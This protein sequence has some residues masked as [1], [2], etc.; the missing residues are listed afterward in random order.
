[1]NAYNTNKNVIEEGDMFNNPVNF[2][3]PDGMMSKNGS[4]ITKFPTPPV[5]P[6]NYK[7]GSNMMGGHRSRHG[8]LY[9]M[10]VAMNSRSTRRKRHATSKKLTRR[11]N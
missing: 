4:L 11:T 6:Q 7:K 1:M 10:L 5:A 2:S 3:P 8:K 9:K